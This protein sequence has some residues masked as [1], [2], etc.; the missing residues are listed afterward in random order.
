MQA[1]ILAAGLSKR[2]RPLT[3]NSPKCLLNIGNKNL[4]HRTV[5]NVLD[6]GIHDFIIV[7]GYKEDMIKNYINENFSQINVEF[8][9]NSDYANNNNSYSL[10][11]TK[12]FVREDVILLDSDILFDKLIIGD[13]MNSSYENCLAVNVTDNLDEEQIKIIT[14]DKYRILHIGK[15]VNI[16]KSIGESIG[17]EKFSLY[18]MKELF[19]IL[20]RKILQENIVNEFYEVSFQ[21]MIDK[22]KDGN[23]MYAI[24]V[25]KYDCLEIDTIEDYDKAQK[26]CI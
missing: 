6:N 22:K 18:F 24:D 16:V 23:S 12:Q 3:D 25:S 14:D 19:A 5:L 8:I 4:L 2:L 21:E 20:D 11:M 26:I 17:I 13:L 10:W 15:Q 9:T 7:T 1:I